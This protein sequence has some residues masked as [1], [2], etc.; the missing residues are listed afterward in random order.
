MDHLNNTVI[1]RSNIEFF[2]LKVCAFLSLFLFVF[3]FNPTY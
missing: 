3:V 1:E 2:I